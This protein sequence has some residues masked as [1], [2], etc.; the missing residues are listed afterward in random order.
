[1]E[2]RR[3][4]VRRRIAITLLVGAIVVA[5]GVAEAVMTCPSGGSAMLPEGGDG[6]DL[7][8]T[9]TCTVGAG[10]YAYGNVNI[11]GTAA[12]PAI[13]R[14]RDATITFS[15]R[16]ILVENYGSLLAGWSMMMRKPRPIGTRAGSR[17]TIRLY[18]AE[19]DEPIACKSGPTCGVDPAIW[20]SN[21]D[22]TKP[23]VQ[24]SLPGGSDFFYNYDVMPLTEAQGTRS[25]FGTKV[26]AVSY[27]GTL[28]IFGKRGALYGSG[29]ADPAN[30]G[31]SWQRLDRSL[32][33]GD[34]TLLVDGTVDWREDDH[35][36]ITTTDYLPGHS[37][38]LIITGA[39]VNL[40]KKRTKIHFT[41]ATC[42][43]GDTPSCGVKWHHWGEKYS[44]G[45][46]EHPGIGRLD[47]NID[48]VDT[49]GAV[50]LLTRS[51]PPRRVSMR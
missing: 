4:A 16:S 33:P 51:V 5:A 43:P 44:L 49:R 18:G 42:P 30:S 13:L 11:F 22:P 23:P 39:S 27:G 14:F 7:E 3:S 34:E 45:K 32:A 24:T 48:S 38:E 8:V 47:L 25:Y 10:E 21:A 17:L 15:A 6:Q 40:A 36:V 31:R 12:Q 28:R 2:E 41:K 35:I 46:K 9:G 29:D 37:E 19:S 1:M 50:A 26:L 20:T